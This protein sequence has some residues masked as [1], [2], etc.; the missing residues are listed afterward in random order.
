MR[1]LRLRCGEL[2]HRRRQ[3]FHVLDDLR[4]ELSAPEDLGNFSRDRG[5]PQHDQGGTDRHDAMVN[6]AP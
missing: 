2:R 5:L 6:T 4:V 1:H 3:L